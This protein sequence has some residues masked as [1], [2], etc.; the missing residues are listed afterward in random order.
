MFHHHE[1]PQQPDLLQLLCR[2]HVPLCYNKVILSH[3]SP[4]G[5]GD[6][7]EGKKQVETSTIQV[8]VFQSLLRGITPLSPPEGVGV[9]EDTLKRTSCPTE[10]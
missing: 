1:R 9:A 2:L 10:R 3:S 5:G 4:L 8:Q 7:G 6:G